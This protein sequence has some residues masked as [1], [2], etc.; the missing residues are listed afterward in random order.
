CLPLGA[1]RAPLPG[2]G[3]A[4]VVAVP[5]RGPFTLVDFAAINL[6][7]GLRRGLGFLTRLSTHQ[8]FIL[9]GPW[10]VVVMDGGQ[11]RVVEQG[12]QLLDAATGLGLELA[13]AG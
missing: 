6:G 8:I 13:A 1:P 5:V 2:G 9:I 12:E 10:L 4:T 11:V 7:D 3:A